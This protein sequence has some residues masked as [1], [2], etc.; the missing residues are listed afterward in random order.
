M[1]RR[2]AFL[3]TAAAAAL[4]LS[5][6]SGTP[7]AA[8]IETGT[9]DPDASLTVGLVL[10][11]DNLDIRHTSGAAL[12]QVLVDNVY[13]GL[14][15]RTEDNEIVPALASDYEVSDDGLTYTFTL[16]EG[17]TFQNGEPLAVED[18]VTSLTQVKD[19]P[20]I[21]G[22]SDFAGVAS[23]AAADAST[24][25][26]T[27]TEPNQNFLF[28]LTSPAG[29]VFKTGDTTDLQDRRQR[30]RPL[31]AR[32]L[33]P[34]RQPHLPPQRRLLGRGAAGRRGRVPV[35]PRLHRRRQRGPRWQ[36]RRADGGRPQPRA[37]ARGHGLRADRGKD[38]RQGHARLQQRQGAA[39]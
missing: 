16:N 17:V 38:H 36:P 4:V 15:T 2:T 24:V 39:R 10:E 30:H 35:H 31:R 8:P 1:F 21:V 13:Q 34:G 6:C 3:A 37:A 14:V 9:P 5:A 22:N 7:E 26:I 27:L 32:A 33:E 18:V 12:E 23:I 29:L 28:T 11:P 25:V 20:T 19:D